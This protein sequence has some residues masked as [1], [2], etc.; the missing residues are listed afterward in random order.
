MPSSLS[1][2]LE[3]VSSSASTALVSPPLD[4]NASLDSSAVSNNV[5]EASNIPDSLYLVSPAS[6]N[7]SRFAPFEESY[8]D[9]NELRRALKVLSVQKN[10]PYYM[11]HSS[12][13]RVEA[14]CPS[15]R[16]RK[17]QVDADKSSEV[18]LRNRCEF[19]VS[20]NRHANGRV[21]V[22]RA[23]V[24]HSS[25]CAV[26][27]ARLAANTETGTHETGAGAEDTGRASAVTASALLETVLPFMSQLATSRG[28]RDAVKPKDVSDIMKDKFG[29]KP[30]YM[31]AWRALSAFRKQQKE[32][33]SLSYMKLKGY[34]HAFAVTNVGSLV[35]FEHQDNT[36]TTLL[37]RTNPD[38]KLFARAFLCPKP[39]HDALR[40]CRGSMLLSVFLVTSTFGGVVFTATAQDA[41]G[42]NVP[43]AIGLAI[44]ENEDEWRYFLQQLRHA[45]PDLERI[46]TSL[47]HNRGDQLARA[48]HTVFPNSPQSNDVDFFIRTATH[49]APLS[50]SSSGTSI[51]IGTHGPTLRL[52]PS[53][54]WMEALCTKSPLMILVGW[55]SQVARTLFQRY[56][57]YGH[58][59]SEYPA[60]FHSLAAEYEG[61]SSRFDVVRT[62]E[63]EFE[64]IDQQTSVG[65]VVNFAKQTC[66]CGEYDVARFP[67]LHVFLAV[68]HAGMLRTDVIPRIFLMTSL[69]TLYAGR[70]TPIDISNVPSD[71]I[72]IPQPLPKTRGRPRKVQQIQQ[73]GDLKQEKLSC[74]VCGVKGH[75]KRTCKRL[76]NM[77]VPTASTANVGEVQADDV[78]NDQ[79][80]TTFLVSTYGDALAFD[81]PALGGNGSES[82]VSNGQVLHLGS[83]KRRR[84]TDHDGTAKKKADEDDEDETAGVALV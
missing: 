32:D 53:M 84:L 2:V 26:L 56:E 79:D 15:W 67:C 8:N 63:S 25:T 28:G 65:R 35:A 49:D 13:Q 71:G 39:L 37:A 23:I 61:V 20:A 80:D 4:S 7:V 9:M 14:R 76:T 21:Y 51:T 73:F 62:S 19:V 45:F 57:R 29:V 58:L 78:V 1:P 54:Q 46:V 66:T 10:A 83:S 41:M 74:S 42:D 55:V 81:N 77:S 70:I 50:D 6:L 16:H 68:T 30:S 75:N 72:T 43:M 40:Y 64:V 44:E 24:T 3:D 60:E 18:T 47:V 22:T 12:P 11:Q 31:T 5:L 33:D 48:I 17:R 69:K 34:L 52:D 82:H 36:R 27:H 59:S 38:A